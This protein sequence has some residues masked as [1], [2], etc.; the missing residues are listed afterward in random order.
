MLSLKRTS[1]FGDTFTVFLSNKLGLP[2]V[3]ATGLY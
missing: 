3:S 2:T 1:T